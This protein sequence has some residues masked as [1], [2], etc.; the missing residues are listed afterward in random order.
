MAVGRTGEERARGPLPPSMNATAAFVKNKD[1]KH[2]DVRMREGLCIKTPP[3][4]QA[5]GVG[6]RAGAGPASYRHW[7]GEGVAM[8]C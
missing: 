2:P 3:R 1:V 6:P 7:P 4:R 5:E 8:K